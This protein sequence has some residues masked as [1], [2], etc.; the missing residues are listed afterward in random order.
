MV[1]V[2][3]AVGEDV[4]ERLCAADREADELNEGAI[5]ERGTAWCRRRWLP[6]CRLIH[7]EADIGAER[8]VF[9]LLAHIPGGYR[10]DPV[11]DIVG[12]VAGEA[13]LRRHLLNEPIHDAAGAGAVSAWTRRKPPSLRQVSVPGM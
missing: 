3:A 8:A 11:V 1:V 2:G 4:E 9:G 5:P 7:A 13:A 10:A 6:A 12:Q